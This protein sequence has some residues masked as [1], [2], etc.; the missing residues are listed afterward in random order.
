MNLSENSTISHYRILEKLGSGGMGVVYKAED[1]KLKRTV[2][3]KFLPSEHIKDEGAK[4]RFIHEAQASSSLEHQNICNIHEIDETEDGIIFIVMACYEGETL[5]DRIAKGPLKIT[6]VFDI[7]G[8]ISSGLAKAHQQDIVHR[9]I[10][11]G[12]IFITG[13]GVV[14]ILDFGL[15]KLS[16]RTVL[17]KEGSTLGTVSHMSPEQITG[18]N[19]DSRS[20]IWSLGVVLY[21]MLTGQLPFKGDYDQA[22]MYAI[23]N[24]TAEPIS[25]LRS[26]VSL[27]LER[28]IE[29]AL[30]KST[31]ERYQ[32]VEDV[33][34]DL[35]RLKKDITA[36]TVK[37]QEIRQHFVKANWKF[38]VLISTGVVVVILAILGLTGI[39]N[40]SD[41]SS[42]ITEYENS[43]AVLPFSTITRSE[44]DQIFADGIHDDILT[45]LTNI[46]HLKV[47]A[48]TSVLQ[49]RNTTK[50]MSEIGAE[51]GV[52]FLLEGSVRRA[53]S[54][55]RIIAQLIDPESEGHIW[56]ETY[57]REYKDIF[58]IQSDVATNIAQ[59]LKTQISEDEAD[60]IAEVPTQN[61]EAYEYYQRGN[62]YWENSDNAEGNQRAVEIYVKAVELDP[63]FG[64]AYAQLAEAC[65]AQ[66]YGFKY[67]VAEN[68]K[69]AEHALAKAKAL[70]PDH[71]Q[72]AIAVSASYYY[73]HREYEEAFQLINK[74][75]KQFPNNVDLIQEA[76]LLLC[77]LRRLDDALVYLKKQYELDPHGLFSGAWVGLVYIYQR[78]WKEAQP[79]ADQFTLRKPTLF[80]GY[81]QRSRIM[82]EGYGKIDEAI[83]LMEQGTTHI[84]SQRERLF[85]RLWQ[86]WLYKRDYEKSLEVLK[87]QKEYKFHLQKAISYDLMNGEYLAMICYDSARISYE[88]ALAE[89]KTDG[90]IYA[91]LGLSYAGLGNKT[92]ALRMARQAVHM[93]P[94]GNDAA[95][96]GEIYLLNLVFTLTKCGDYDEA[97]EHLETLLSIPSHVTVWMLKLDPRFDPLRNHEEFKRILKQY[98]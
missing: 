71:P 58:A 88:N 11:P 35:R 4:K 45:Q 30:S 28:I 56:A 96:H 14:K 1:T 5:K 95:W 24:E 81:E 43:I 25:G 10:K 86:L 78:N 84:L 48:R 22:V 23:V 75:L 26:G 44:E 63:E 17:T 92:A 77:A 51:L 60:R 31:D 38:P 54:Q 93:K 6:E 15:A 37:K 74:V 67:N 42:F 68:K 29:K 64:L 83:R 62:Y 87:S 7:A 72:T 18:E 3:L 91:N 59:A 90:H 9:D 8:Q 41:E 20:D 53:G 80:W 49:Y 70:S 76:G 73:V 19:V 39:F 16:G 21:E 61:M 97:C 69:L 32:H 57:D 13:D 27:E 50:R 94:V 65:F 2:A 40:E 34:T 98:R 47:I 36:D 46:R 66:A 89:N 33:L 52:N 82:T 55:I 79:W 12:N 85:I